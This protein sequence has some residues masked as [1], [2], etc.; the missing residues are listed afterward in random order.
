MSN[1]PVPKMGSARA[2]LEL[3][4]GI[5]RPVGKQSYGTTRETGNTAVQQ[6]RN[7]R[8]YGCAGTRESQPLHFLGYL[9][10]M[11]Q[12]KEQMQQQGRKRWHE[13]PGTL[14]ATPHSRRHHIPHRSADGWICSE[15]SIFTWHELRRRQDVLTVFYVIFCY[16]IYTGKTIY[17]FIQNKVVFL[18]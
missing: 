18:E 4:V 13:M 7:H 10:A 3:G 6:Q 15:T 9:T 17:Y 12:L 16:E 2:K 14:E 8:K 5:R 1:I 11:Q